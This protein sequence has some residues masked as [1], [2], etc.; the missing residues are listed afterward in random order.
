[1]GWARGAATSPAAT[2]AKASDIGAVVR[3]GHPVR[4]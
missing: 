1:L 3:Y 2:A 4:L